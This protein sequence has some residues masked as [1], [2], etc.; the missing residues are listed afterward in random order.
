[1]RY[2]IVFVLFIGISCQSEN[3]QAEN[4]V[5]ISA[6]A[7]IEPF[8]NSLKERDVTHSL[9]KLLAN[10]N[11]IRIDDSVTLDL[12]RKFIHIHEN[13]GAYSSFRLVKAKR[14]GDDIAVYSYLV[15]YSEKFYR[16]I[17]MFYNNGHSVRLYKFSF[18]D[19]MAVEME[20]SLKYYLD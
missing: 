2:L 6:K 14:V 20:E 8:L 3:S 10:N 11:N 18:D 4:A 12:K 1:M 17:F 7:V 15:K 16:F 9:E 5:D 13:S 19:S